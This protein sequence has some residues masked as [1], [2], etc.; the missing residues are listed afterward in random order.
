MLKNIPNSFTPELLKK[1]MEM[2]HGEDL[3]IAD[4][5]FPHKS[6]NFRTESIYLPIS[7]ITEF[8]KDILEFFP[9]DYIVEHAALAIH[10][11]TEGKRYGE[12]SKLIEENGS[13][14]GIVQRFDFYEI[15]EKAMCVVITSDATKGAGILLKKGVSLIEGEP[16]RQATE[17][18]RKQLA[19]ARE[20]PK[21][22]R[23][24]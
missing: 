20:N 14:L 22:Q 17:N 6:M 7:N 21:Y 24:L 13:K 9:L 10:S 15:V 3:F 8:L 23:W 5:N 1:L 18:Q 12:F 2:G 16:P 4:G 11:V 19:L